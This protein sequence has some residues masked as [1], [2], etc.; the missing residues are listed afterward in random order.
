MV[1]LRISGEVTTKSKRTRWRF[2]ERL[3]YNVRD[4]LSREGIEGEV[5]S[6]WDRIKVRTED[7]RAPEV[8][9]RVFGVRSVSAAVE[10]PFREPGEI[11]REG[12]RLF[13]E[14]VRG[15]RFAVRAR[16]VG[17]VR[18]SVQEL[19][20]SLG[21]ALYPCSGGVDLEEPEITVH[22]EVLSLIHI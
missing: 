9:R 16:T 6:G 20:R 3:V 10:R 11:V 7:G 17:N 1:L 14:L 2:L 12:E 15:K 13:R 19:E 8:L 22:V 21:A 18:L 5:E 4:A